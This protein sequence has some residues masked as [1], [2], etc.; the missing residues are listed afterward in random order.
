MTIYDVHAHCIPAAL[1][2]LLR[3][4]GERFG[5]EMVKEGD[6]EYAVLAG[7]VELGPLRP[8]LSDMDA[9]LRAMDKSGVDIQLLSSWIDLTAYSLEPEAGAEYSR[10]FNEMLAQEAASSRDRFSP[11]GTVPLQNPERAAAE[12]AYAIQELGMVGVQIA[13]TVD[14][15]D[16]DR[17]G[18]DP[19]WEA[20]ESLGCLVVLHPCNPLPGVDLSRNFLDNTVGR[21]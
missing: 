4:E 1:L 12:L 6:D 9:R 18:L 5:I 11:L 21:P 19:F 20:A 2:D 15:T 16:L 7:R 3:Q 10:R 8:I 14:R 13:T 17:A